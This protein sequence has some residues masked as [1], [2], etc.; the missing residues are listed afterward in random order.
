MVAQRGASHKRNAKRLA[1][2]KPPSDIEKDKHLHFDEAVVTVRAGAGGRGAVIP[3]DAAGEGRRLK[4]TSDSDFELPPGGGCGGDV[5]LF[6]DP[7]LSDLLHLRGRRL[8]AAPSGGDSLGLR[9]LPAAYQRQREMIADGAAAGEDVCVDLSAVRLRD[10]ANLRVP[11]PPGTFVRT[12][13][14]RVLGDL[15]TPAQELRVASGGE[16]GPCLLG[17]ESR[18][19]PTRSGK[20]RGRPSFDEMGTDSDDAFALDDDELSDMTRGKPAEEVTVELI[21]CAMCKAHG[22]SCMA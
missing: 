3:P 14:G 4:R 1:V 12:K 20:G 18:K 2:R 7:A 11:V 8:L 13:N 16:G 19:K 21:L 17:K 22:A 6:V 10:G 9:D 15:V 5:I